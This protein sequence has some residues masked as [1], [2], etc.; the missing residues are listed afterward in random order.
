MYEFLILFRL[1]PTGPT[2]YD[3]AQKINLQMF[4]NTKSFSSQNVYAK[5]VGWHKKYCNWQLQY[6]PIV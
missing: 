3:P 6:V 1:F 2:L 5:L 4:Q